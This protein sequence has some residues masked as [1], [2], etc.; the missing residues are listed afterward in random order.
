MGA[1]FPHTTASGKPMQHR[2]RR[3]WETVG[4]NQLLD[5]EL[6]ADDP[7]SLDG[8]VYTLPE[9]DEEPYLEYK[10]DLKGSGREML[11][12]VHC[13]QAHFLG[14]VMR[15]GAHRIF[16]GHIC[17]KN[18][19]GENFEHYTADFNAALNRQDAL[20]RV[21]DIKTATVGFGQWL[22][23]VQRS[24]VFKH[25]AQVRGR[26]REH[27]PWVFDNVERAATQNPIVKGVPVPGALFAEG[28]DP[29]REFDRLTTEFTVAALLLSREPEE[30][31][32]RL[33][34][35]KARLDKLLRGVERVLADLAL[36]QQLFQPAVVQLVCELANEWDNPKKRRYQ[37]GLLAI[38]CKRDRDSTTIQ[39]PGGFA[40]PDS[41]PITELRAAL[42]AA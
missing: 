24:E 9:G 35:I 1:R 33:P 30:A 4:D 11:R 14:Y 20:R 19:Y 29:R 41:A 42:R 32:K 7:E 13:N 31:A 38:T 25:F 6:T 28:T 18:I 15:K 37:A 23:K 22:E 16:V 12:C 39:L 3:H 17:G 26:F 40:L 8:M 21:R 5:V 2:I 27:M 34:Q 36:V 10:Y